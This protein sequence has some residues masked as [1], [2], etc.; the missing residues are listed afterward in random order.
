[1]RLTL[2]SVLASWDAEEYGLIGSTEWVEEYADWLTDTAVAYLNL[3]VAVAGPRLGLSTT[4]E[5]HDLAT[6]VFKKVIAPN[7]G[8]FNESLY[9]S[10]QR[11]TGGTIGVLGSGSDYTPFLHYGIS[12]VSLPTFFRWTSR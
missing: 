4:P 7:G 9:E 2:P 10:W 5:L 3:D 6:R 11:D 1:M 8:K 12:S